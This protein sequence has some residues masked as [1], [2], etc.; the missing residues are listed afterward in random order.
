MS[1][2]LE[3]IVAN[4]E[5]TTP[6]NLSVTLT[7]NGVI[8]HTLGS[9]V[10]GVAFPKLTNYSGAYANISIATNTRLRIDTAFNGSTFALIYNDRSSTTFSVVTAA[11]AGYNAQTLGTTSFDVT[12]PETVR[13][14][15]LG[16]I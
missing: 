8:V 2:N 4:P 1:L 5:T 10:A 14:H 6:N 13:L 16:Y 9:N 3:N 7:A 12:T 11:G 15:N